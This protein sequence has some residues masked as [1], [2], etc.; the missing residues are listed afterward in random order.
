MVTFFV[1]DSVNVFIFRIYQ[2]ISSDRKCD[3]I[4]DCEDGSDEDNC[5]CKEFL[6][7]TFPEAICDGILDCK[8][9]TDEENCCE[10]FQSK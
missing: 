4:S 6:G 8:D 10:Y 9:G 7:H 5:S 3:R 2:P 1:F